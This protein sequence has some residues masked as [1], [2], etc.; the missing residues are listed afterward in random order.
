MV[1]KLIAHASAIFLLPVFE[2]SVIFN[3]FRAIL[4]SI[5]AREGG[6]TVCW[7]AI[8]R[9]MTVLTY[10]FPW[11]HPMGRLQGIEFWSDAPKTGS[12]ARPYGP[13]LSVP[14]LGLALQAS[15]FASLGASARKQPKCWLGPV[16]L[17][18]RASQM[19]RP[20]LFRLFDVRLT[21]SDVPRST[22][23]TLSVF[24]ISILK[25]FYLLKYT[26]VST[27]VPSLKSI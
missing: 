5:S 6:N 19:P 26:F 8:A 15:P 7:K 10:W 25:C 22:P 11:K 21:V 24:F 14:N 1:K 12:S 3:D 16:G 2:K 13:R 20:P 9:K 17:A 18:F 4:H 23:T 27:S